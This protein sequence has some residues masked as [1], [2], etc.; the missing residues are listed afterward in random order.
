MQAR[1]LV[2]FRPEGKMCTQQ[3]L[4]SITFKTIRATMWKAKDSLSDPVVARGFKKRVPE[5]LW[6]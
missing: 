2:T 6:F 1:L 4:H 3:I 5:Y